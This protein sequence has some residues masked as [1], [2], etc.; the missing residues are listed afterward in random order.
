MGQLAFVF[1]GQGAQ[2]PGMGRGLYSQSAAA[3]LVFD[4]AERL[5]PGLLD[6]CFDGPME[7]LTRTEVAQPALFTVSLA[8]ALAGEEL[9]LVPDAVAGFSLGEWTAI[10]FAGMLD[11][12]QA[13]GLVRQRGQW[14]Q[15][16]A[17][18]NPGGMTALLR[19]GEAEVRESLAG[20][21]QV[22]PVNFNAPDQVVVAGTLAALTEYE[23]ALKAAGRRYIR[24]N[25]AGGF[26]SPLM[27]EASQKLQ[28]ALAQVQLRQPR[29]PVYSNLTALPY[30]QGQ[31]A[32]TLAKQ[33]K[34]PVLWSDSLRNMAADGISQFTEIGPGKVLSGL[35]PKTLPGA[36]VS[37]AEDIQGLMHVL[38]TCKENP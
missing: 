2:A 37:Q 29:M 6:L 28:A 38:K 21:H 14:M 5:M 17:D 20:H 34:S 3:R 27:E 26:H 15:Q 24:L 8:C 25:V 33:L 10:C 4:Q 1:P 18:Q 23:V 31:A 30:Q 7:A 11:F 35:I 13:F 12:S 16:C 19:L 9:G 22:W 36:K 32:D